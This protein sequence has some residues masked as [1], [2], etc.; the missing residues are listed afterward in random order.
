MRYM[1]VVAVQHYVHNVDERYV[2]I[3]C[4]V[5]NTEIRYFVVPRL[6]PFTTYEGIG[7]GL[8]GLLFS[9][10]AIRVHVLAVRAYD[11]DSLST[12]HAHAS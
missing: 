5:Q 3:I 7:S 4:F 9:D 2:K 6:Q 12:A 10:H 11:R 8:T 1:F